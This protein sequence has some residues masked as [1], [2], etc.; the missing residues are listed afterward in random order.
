MGHIP[1]S[2]LALTDYWIRVCHALLLKNN[3]VLAVHKVE[4]QIEAK[5]GNIITI[6]AG[7]GRMCGVWVER[8]GRVSDKT[9]VNSQ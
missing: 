9:L 3:D 1:E 4:F 8:Y 7:P 6:I 2:V 5:N